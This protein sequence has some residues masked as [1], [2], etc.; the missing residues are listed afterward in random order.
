L[1]KAKR[2][3]EKGRKRGF[4][5]RWGCDPGNPEKQRLKAKNRENVECGKH[6]QS[7]NNYNML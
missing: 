3:E 7:Q 6:K 4:R 5:R 1:K 2:K